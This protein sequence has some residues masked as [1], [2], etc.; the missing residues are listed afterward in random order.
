MEFKKSEWIGNWVNFE[1][2]IYSEN[3]AMQQCWNEAEENAKTMPMFINMTTV[4]RE[5]SAF[6]F[7]VSEE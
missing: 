3:A 6:C 7:P 5:D 2:Y 4:T 1:R